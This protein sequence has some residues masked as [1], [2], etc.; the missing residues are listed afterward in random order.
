[1]GIDHKYLSFD[2]GIDHNRVFA[3]RGD[4]FITDGVFKELDKIEKDDHI[5]AKPT[6]PVLI[7][8]DDQYN[9]DVVLALAFSSKRGSDEQ[10]AINSYRSIKVPSV[11]GDGRASY[12]DV[13][14]VFTINVY[15][16][17]V[18]IGEA[19]KAIVDAAVALH[20]LHSVNDDSMNTM[21]KVL[22]DKFPD[23]QPFQRVPAETSSIVQK[24]VK[25]TVNNMFSPSTEIFT[26]VTQVPLE[27]LDMVEKAPI[28]EQIN[29]DEALRLYNDW[30]KMGTDPFRQKYGLTN[31]Q[32]Y[33]LRDKCVA[34]LLGKVSNFKKFDWA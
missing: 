33:T 27:E 25:F 19:S 15:Q 9:Q 21:M 18:K 4:I 5:V 34:Q 22:K 7:I 14:Q 8:S 26:D 11:V 29:K 6:R 10:S 31:Q 23:A 1:M 13:S 17:R 30:L 12:I 24:E 16:L 3:H 2:T 20:T 32:Y 28:K